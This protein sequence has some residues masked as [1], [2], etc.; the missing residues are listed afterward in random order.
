VGNLFE[1]DWIDFGT[2]MGPALLYLL[3]CHK[4]YWPFF[5]FASLQ[6]LFAFHIEATENSLT[7]NV[8]VISFYAVIITVQVQWKKLARTVLFCPF[9]YHF[10]Y[11]RCF[12]IDGTN[13]CL[14][15]L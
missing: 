1:Q 8:A 11:Y 15:L 3:V 5:G 4:D 12:E 6:T 13:Y 9:W 14:A 10:S 2:Y 7:S